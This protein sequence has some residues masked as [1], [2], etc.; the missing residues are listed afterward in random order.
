MKRLCIIIVLVCS[1]VSLLAEVTIRT[2]VS[3]GA[4][5]KDCLKGLG[6]CSAKTTTN[7][8]DNTRLTS[9][10]LSDDESILTLRLSRASMDELD[11][12]INNDK[13]IQDDDYTLPVE[14]SGALGAMDLLVIPAGSYPVQYKDGA[15]LVRLSVKSRPTDLR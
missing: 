15:V 5:K 14:V 3:F 4:K 1:C 9:L 7:E 12:Q 10:T 6:M 8:S 11:G 13:F 2:E